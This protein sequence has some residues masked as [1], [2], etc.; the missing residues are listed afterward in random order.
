MNMQELKK[1]DKKHAQRIADYLLTRIETDLP[2]K[3]KLES[4]SKTLRGCVSYCKEQAR[5]QA[6]DNCAMITDDEVFEWCVHY[7]LEDSLD[8]EHKS[9][10]KEN[11]KK[12]KTE[13][14]ETLFGEEEVVIDKKKKS[15]TKAEKSK[16]T[17]EENFIEQLSLF[18]EMEI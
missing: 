14:V 17:I 4:T 15:T 10:S 6:E 7:F 2:L 11:D 1:Q 9:T 18:D 5:N 3:E 8:C 16:K 13:K 12:P